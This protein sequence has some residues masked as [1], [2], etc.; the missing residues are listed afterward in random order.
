[1]LRLPAGLFY[2]FFPYKANILRLRQVDKK[3]VT[4]PIKLVV[5]SGCNLV[6]NFLCRV[7]RFIHL[8]Y[9][10]K[11]FG[12]SIVFEVPFPPQSS[13]EKVRHCII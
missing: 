7:A 6:A 13:T 12:V 1:M 11:D 5:N 10:Q 9:D 8:R 4:D 2:N 3:N